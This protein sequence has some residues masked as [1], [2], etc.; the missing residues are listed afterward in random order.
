MAKLICGRMYRFSGA[1][2]DKNAARELAKEFET[3]GDRCKIMSEQGEWRIY[4][5]PKDGK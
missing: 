5:C 1:S 2:A 3:L 4:C